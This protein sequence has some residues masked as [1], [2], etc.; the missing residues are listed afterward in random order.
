[1]SLSLKESR[2][3]AGLAD[4]LYDFL[5]GSGRATWAGHVNFATVAAKVGIGEFWQA[6][7]KKPAISALLSH[8]LQQ[9]RGLFEKLVVELVRAALV[10][11]QAQGNPITAQEIDELNGGILELGFRF[12]DLW[13]A[14]FRASLQQSASE[15]A[16]ENVEV[17]NAQ[18]ELDESTRNRSREL[19]QLKTR[20]FDLEALA[21]RNK[22]GI[23]LEELLNDLFHLHG[24]SPRKG[25]RVVGE[26]IDGS[27]EFEN[28]VYLVESKWEKAPLPESDLLVFRGKI[29]G[30]STFTRGVFIALNGISSAAIDAIT[31]GKAP[32]FFVVN[33]YDLL[34][35]L[36]ESM[37]MAEFLR[38]RIRMLAEEGRVC[39]SFQELR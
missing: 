23:A 16:R 17:S 35:I 14:G 38:K 22:A 1:M 20:F 11:R 21:D 7:S 8:T 39:A 25:F 26:Q 28:Q 36:S 9:R 18:K 15:R 27:F 10:Y 6:G 13:D 24:L 34:M 33:G 30:K 2:A 3:I 32:S 4:T 12:P 31:R 5:P 19:V 29:E 37:S